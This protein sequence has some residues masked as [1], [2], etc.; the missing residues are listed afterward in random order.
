MAWR[1]L[2]VIPGKLWNAEEREKIG[3]TNWIDTERFRIQRNLPGISVFVSINGE[4]V[5]RGCHGLSDMENGT[6]MSPSSA[7]RIASISK[8]FAAMMVAKEVEN[9]RISLADRVQKFID[10]PEKEIPVRIENLL[11]HTSGVRHYSKKAK[12]EDMTDDD[13]KAADAEFKSCIRY[14]NAHQASK[15]FRDDELLFTEGQ[16]HYTTYGFTLLEDVLETVTGKSFKTLLQNLCKEIGI[17]NTC[18]DV[19]EEIIPNRARGYRMKITESKKPV[20]DYDK[21]GNLLVLNAPPV[22]LS[23]KYAGG[24]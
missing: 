13:K 7:V 21:G 6:K 23:N 9:G 12:V 18:L 1:N 8:S 20:A 5:Y 10:F 3:G 11:S 14:E 19:P 24:G 4:T 22:D 15:I 16:F 2:A 17:E